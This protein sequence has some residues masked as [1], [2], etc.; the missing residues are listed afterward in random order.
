VDYYGPNSFG[1]LEMAVE[2]KLVFSTA[3]YWPLK[4]R[5]YF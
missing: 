3:R 5:N 4:I 2:T 1:R